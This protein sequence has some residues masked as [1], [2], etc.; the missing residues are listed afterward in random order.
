MFEKDK[1]LPEGYEVR[2]V[3]NDLGDGEFSKLAVYYRGLPI[4]KSKFVEIYGYKRILREL[5]KVIRLHRKNHI[6]N[7]LED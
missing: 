2:T 4:Y 1:P 3:D 7:Y 5:R 6:D